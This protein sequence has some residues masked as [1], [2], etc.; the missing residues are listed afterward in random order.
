M[1]GIITKST[2]LW[3][4]VRTENGETVPCRLRGKFRIDGNKNTNPAVVGDHVS[5]DLEKDNTG[6]ITE[7]EK[8]KNYIDRKST[9]LSKINHLIAANIDQ[10]FL[11]VTLKEPR[12]SLG[13]I[14]RF[15]VACEGFRIPVCI[16]F[17]KMDIYSLKEINKIEELALLYQSIGYEVI[18]SSII[19]N[20]GIGIIKKMMQGKVSLF[21]GHSGV[22]KSA[23]IN[24]I[25][26]EL[27][28]KVGEISQFHNK[29][30]HTTTF[31]QMFPLSQSGFIIDTPGIKEFGLIQYSRE[32]IRDYFPEIR[33]YNNQCRFHNCCHVNEPDCA[34]KKAVEERKIPSSR[35]LNYLAILQADDMK[36]ADWQLL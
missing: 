13:F 9:K 2:G 28:L 16:V 36:L 6:F 10:A 3:Y 24:S 18:Q 26:A 12:T 1:K 4:E 32:E 35:Y 33:A 17:N 29:G 27:H 21:S 8:R 7:I 14:D 31:A 23:M 11:L 19:E 15:L 25:D 20:K 34:V 30:K 5:F 22:G